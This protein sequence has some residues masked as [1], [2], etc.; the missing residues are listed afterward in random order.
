MSIIQYVLPTLVAQIEEDIYFFGD[1]APVD[2]GLFTLL[3]RLQPRTRLFHLPH[4]YN[5]ISYI[6]SSTPSVPLTPAQIILFITNA[7]TFLELLAKTIERI[8]ELG[9]SDSVAKAIDSL[10]TTISSNCYVG[11]SWKGDQKAK[12]SGAKNRLEG[13]IGEDARKEAVSGFTTRLNSA[14]EKVEMLLK[15]AKSSDTAGTLSNLMRRY[16]GISNRVSFLSFS[17]S[18]FFLSNFYLFFCKLQTVPISA[19]LSIRA[20]YDLVNF[21]KGSKGS[22]SKFN[23]TTDLI[24]LNKVALIPV[25]RNSII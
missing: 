19:I 5:S 10:E 25:S 18:S 22:T 1:T 3:N 7:T 23:I 6:S 4:N 11:S 17:S 9:D 2:T 13:F 21:G 20:P 14:I 12:L 15:V 16:G 24:L 8:E